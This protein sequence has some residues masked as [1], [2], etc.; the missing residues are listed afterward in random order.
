MN[1]RGAFF[2]A[3]LVIN[4]GKKLTLSHKTDEM[5]E[6]KLEKDFITQPEL[7][8]L[9]LMVSDRE[10]SVALYPPVAREEIL[11]RNF[12]LDRDTPDRLK[13]IEDIVYDNPL[14]LCDFKRVD[15]IVDSK[16]FMILPETVTDDDMNL[17][18]SSG[19]FDDDLS[20]S[21]ISS[22]AENTRLLQAMDTKV[23]S[24]LKRTFYNITFR[25]KVSLLASYFISS[26]DNMPARKA[27]AL[28]NGD[29]LTFLGAE[30]HRLLAANEF[31]FRRPA[32][33][34]YY[35][36]ASMK[37]L[38]MEPDDP[39]VALAVRRDINDDENSINALLKPYV[40]NIMTIPFPML[41]Y[42]AS[43]STLLIPFP[44]LLLPICE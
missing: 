12:T 40:R 38:G 23:C 41:R 3:N 19:G 8:R 31:E 33:A 11:W 35:I 25:S 29:R 18:L 1:Y 30:G 37:Q 43:R 36:L 13:A 21:V 28:T 34:A 24:F 42:R 6:G 32:D 27:L 9:A 20:S 44:L 14:L 5:I 10:L 2:N 39:E 7:W 4:N 16:E 17:F 15:C 22:P 26:T